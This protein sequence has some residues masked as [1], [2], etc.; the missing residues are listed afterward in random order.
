MKDNPLP[1]HVGTNVVN[2]VAGC[3]GDFWIFD[4]NLVRGDLVKMHVDFYE[5]SYYTHDHAGCGICSTN[6]QG[7]DKIKADL[8]EMMDEGLIHIIR[9]GAEYKEDVNMVYGCPS[10]FWIFYVNYMNDDLV[11][12]HATF[13]HMDGQEEHHYRSCQIYCRASRG[14]S[15]IR[16]GVQL[17]LDNGT[18]KVT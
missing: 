9:P 3:Q 15:I 2:M 4:I 14:Y 11:Q 13:W 6:V 16:R 8:Q 12:L 18:I 7:C 5:F 1:K 17:F 10:E